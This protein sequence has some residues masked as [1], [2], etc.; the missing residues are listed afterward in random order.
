MKD[1]LFSDWH[2]QAN[3]PL[4]V[5]YGNP[6][7]IERLKDIEKYLPPKPPVY[8]ETSRREWMERY[9][10]YLKDDGLAHST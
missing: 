9:G 1:G 2:G 4:A 3:F 8:L 5:L 6:P 7:F 10:R